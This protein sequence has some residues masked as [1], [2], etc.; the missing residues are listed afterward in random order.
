M[1]LPKPPRRRPS[2]PS[3]RATKGSRTNVCRTQILIQ[4]LTM[5]MTRGSPAHAPSPWIVLSNRCMRIF[6]N[7]ARLPNGNNKHQYLRNCIC[8]AHTEFARCPQTSSMCFA[9]NV[10]WKY[11]GRNACH[12]MIFGS[13]LN[14]DIVS[15]EF[16]ECFFFSVNLHSK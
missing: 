13:C 4:I 16:L 3:D 10:C 14:A 15:E 1:V 5:R 12:E 8:R 7:L 2:G 9:N 6:R 11:L